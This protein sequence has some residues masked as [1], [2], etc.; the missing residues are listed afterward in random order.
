LTPISAAAIFGRA[1][2]IAVERAVSDADRL[3]IEALHSAYVARVA[4]TFPGGLAPAELLW[5]RI[6]P[7]QWELEW[8]LPLWLG[9]RLGVDHERS[10]AMVLGN[11]LG[12]A[13]LR[14]QDDV[15]DGEV[16][17]FERER[18]NRLSGALYRLAVAEYRALLPPSSPFWL[19]LELRMAEWQRAADADV[20]PASGGA[21]LYRLASRGAP[22]KL[23][24]RAMVELTSR[25][26]MWPRLSRCLDNALSAMVLFDHAC[27]WQED[28]AGGRPNAF[29]AAA[30]PHA[31]ATQARVFAAMMGGQVIAPYFA[32]VHAA[33]DR[34]AR[35]ADDLRIE[36]LAGYLRRQANAI[37]REALRLDAHYSNLGDVSM[38][39]VFG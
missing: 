34:A 38:A 33:F 35:L 31:P 3:D 30:S 23:C 24:A 6:Q 20:S 22:L 13:S 21:A 17:A 11:V 2:W 10:I 32:T 4:E 19:E 7:G 29:A 12:L 5:R 15:R 16:D 27:D 1:D 37:E 25:Q 36:P 14:L 18:A 8:Y 28:L 9:K 39:I 26:D